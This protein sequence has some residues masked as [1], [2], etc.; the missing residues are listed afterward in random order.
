MPS[1]F[2]GLDLGGSGTRAALA[3]T[4]GAVL[5][6]GIGPTGLQGRGSARRH[7][8]R[9]LDA[10]LAPITA[11]VGN[12]EAVVFAGTRGLSVP[13]RRALLE[14]ELHSRFPN[15]SVRVANDALIGL[16]GGLGG[17]PGIA[18]LAGSGSIALARNAAGVEGRAGG[19]GYLLGD[20]GSGYWIGREAL[21]SYL[22]TLEA[23]EPSSTLH[24]LLNKQR[25]G[26]ASVVD[27][28]TWMYTGEGQVERV[29]TLAP[30]VSRA[31]E[32]GDA[33]AV[34]ILRHAGEALATMAA[35]ASHQ[36]PGTDAT[37][38]CI[39][40]VWSAHAALHDAF[41]TELHQ[42]LPA[43]EIAAPRLPPVGGALL[44]AT[45]ADRGPVDR[46]LVD[47]LSATL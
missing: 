1:L 6:T 29:A 19:W 11:R 46:R 5:A 37:V 26:R 22:R 35:A 24:D 27:V 17:E 3:D 20:E 7:L 28:L 36:V 18:V 32:A 4:E 9:A 13:G 42:A 16:W 12:D 41:A 34:E 25:L 23:R 30:L 44:L 33:T 38:V 39:G 45:G 14:L 40:G 43:A 21:R 10:A 31:A 47:R 8:A 2:V 15:A